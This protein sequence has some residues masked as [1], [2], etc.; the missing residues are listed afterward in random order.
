MMALD[1]KVAALGGRPA[2]STAADCQRAQLPKEQEGGWDIEGCPRL[3]GVDRTLT[4]LD[5]SAGGAPIASLIFGAMHP[6]VAQPDTPLYSSDFVGIAMQTLERRRGDPFVAAFFN[7]AEGDVTA[8]RINRDALEIWKLADVLVQ[9]LETVTDRSPV[10]MTG[11]IDSRSYFAAPGTTFRGTPD[12]QL[13]ATARGGAAAIGGGEGDRTLFYGLGWHER[14]LAVRSSQDQGAKLNALRS[15]VLPV[16]DLTFLIALPDDFPSALPLSYARLG[17]LEFAVAPAE[18]STATGFAIRAAFRATGELVEIGLA[19]EYASYAATEDEYARQDYMAASTLWGPDESE[20]FVRVLMALKTQSSG[21]S[22]V[23][24]EEG[25][26]VDD[27]GIPTPI[28]LAPLEVGARRS[29]I[30]E[31]LDLLLRDHNGN[32]KRNLP[33]ITWNESGNVDPFK[34]GDVEL[35]RATVEQE[36]GPTVAD[37]AMGRIVLLLRGKPQRRTREWVA[38]WLGPLDNNLSADLVRFKITTSAGQCYVSASFDPT[39]D[40]GDR[41]ATTPCRS[42]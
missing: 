2:P 38:I 24:P 29:V 13:A 31:D 26:P 9:S 41:G 8:R 32:P 3:R 6:T 18:M 1:R 11:G 15:K 37:D 34:T 39:R 25:V 28:S 36:N 42:R 17:S 35:P 19:N 12:R 22:N 40:V 7:G 23:L 14:V 30:D 10:D 21:G 4:I 5:V 27:P 16:P 33:F 20:V